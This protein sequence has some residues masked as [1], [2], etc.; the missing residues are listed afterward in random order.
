MSDEPQKRRRTKASFGPIKQ[1]GVAVS[2]GTPLL[3]VGVLMVAILMV[4][5]VGVG[6]FIWILAGTIVALGIAAAISH[7]VL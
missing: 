5:V 1:V 6:T 3:V 7:R 2:I 4:S